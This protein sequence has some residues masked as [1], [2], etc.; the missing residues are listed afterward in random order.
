MDFD[1]LDIRV[2][3]WMKNTV[4]DTIKSHCI[5]W[6]IPSVR[7]VS[8]AAAWS[9]HLAVNLYLEGKVDE[10]TLHLPAIFNHKYNQFEG[11]QDGRVANY[12]H[13]KF[14]M[15]CYM[16]KDATLKEIGAAIDKGAITTTN[17]G[18][19]VRN[20]LVAR[21]ADM[22]I[23]C[24]FGER[25]RLRDGGTAHTMSLFLAKKPL[26]FSW[27]VNLTDEKVYPSATVNKL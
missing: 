12:Y 5:Y 2:Y 25:N 24:T 6:N 18:F 7:L 20:K 14:G 9:D 8:G 4:Y 11:E 15:K 3:N 13:H 26:G 10:L 22:M 27:H 23:A 16:Q 17:Q 1:R 19:F 21:D